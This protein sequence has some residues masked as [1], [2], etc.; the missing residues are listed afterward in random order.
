MCSLNRES[1]QI[2]YLF[3]IVMFGKLA[4]YVGKVTRK[5]KFTRARTANQ[6]DLPSHFRDTNSCLVSHVEDR[7]CLSYTFVLLPH[8]NLSRTRVSRHALV[9]IHTYTFSQA[10]WSIYKSIIHLLVLVLYWDSLHLLPGSRILDSACTTH[11]IDSIASF[12]LFVAPYSEMF[13]NPYSIRRQIVIY[14]KQPVLCSLMSGGKC[15]SWDTLLP[16][17]AR[18][19]LIIQRPGVISHVQ[20]LPGCMVRD[21]VFYTSPWL[22]SPA[23]RGSFRKLPS[24]CSA[25]HLSACTLRY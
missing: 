11:C 4:V 1:S 13:V 23:C 20:S 21:A 22:T 25:S 6:Q 18:R 3:S 2:T 17:E 5:Y 14:A 10:C 7:W 8:P 19:P 15:V 24:G 16:L 9:A 12:L